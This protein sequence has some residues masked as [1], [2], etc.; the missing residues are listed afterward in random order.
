MKLI[1]YSIIIIIYMVT[2]QLNMFEAADLKKTHG[3]NEEA[4]EC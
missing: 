2:W 1:K 3:K 4:S